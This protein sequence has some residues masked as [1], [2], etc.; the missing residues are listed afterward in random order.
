MIVLLLSMSVHTTPLVISASMV[1]SPFLVPEEL[2]GRTGA[3]EGFVV[4]IGES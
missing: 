2:R 1:L 4:V 3:Q